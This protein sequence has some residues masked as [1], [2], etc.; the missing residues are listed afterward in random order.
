MRIG[1][2]SSRELAHRLK[3]PGICL[4][5]GPFITHLKT[6]LP[7]VA[8]T[9]QYLYMDFDLENGHQIVDFHIRVDR[10]KNIR[11]WVRPQA[12]FYLEGDTPSNPMPL[13]LAVPLLE[14]GMNWA[15][16]HN[17]HRFLVIH[18]AVA[19]KAGRALML[20]APP[21]MGKSTLCAALVHRGWRLF[22][23]ELLLI[24]L[25]DGHITPLPR[26][27]GLKNESIAVIRDFVPQA[28]MSP[29]W[30]DT[31]KGTVAHLRPPSDAVRRA[32]ETA[33]PAWIMFLTYRPGDPT[34]LEPVPK[35]RAFLRVADS[36]FNYSVLGLCGFETV[37]NLIDTCDCYE[38]S[39]SRLDE[40]VE[41]LTGLSAPG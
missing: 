2:F 40:A 1:D 16:A 15:I 10:P 13:R 5:T 28:G 20:I 35:A 18:S 39:Y 4:Q 14:W 25:E 33:K 38:F 21:G 27:I 11:R 26:P 8:R 29:E 30:K 41:R 3:D 32:Q 6:P 24:R 37:A 23:D 12:Q 22:S 34:K 9:L 19:E 36:A 31:H 7:L 17:A